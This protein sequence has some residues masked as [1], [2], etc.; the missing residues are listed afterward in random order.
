MAVQQYTL[1]NILQKQED[2]MAEYQRR[3]T[4]PEHPVDLGTLAGQETMRTYLSY[5]LVELSEATEHV[6]N[7]QSFLNID[8]L[9]PQFAFRINGLRAETID[10]FTMEIADVVHFWAECLLL[11]GIDEA[12]LVSSMNLQTSEMRAERNKGGVELED[13]GYANEALAALFEV[14]KERLLIDQYH[15]YQIARESVKLSGHFE[16]VVLKHPYEGIMSRIGQLYL[17][18]HRS[19]CYEIHSYGNKAINTMKLKPWRESGEIG[20]MDKLLSTLLELSA[21]LF[22]WLTMMGFN[23]MTLV[24]FYETKNTQNLKRLDAKW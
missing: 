16:G 1:A 7:L 23:E 3:G 14:G 2:L 24:N 10:D 11:A 5:L 6:D 21:S 13:V 17:D 4:L 22:T 18:F 20:D 9:D 15:L 8:P 19:Y 12:I